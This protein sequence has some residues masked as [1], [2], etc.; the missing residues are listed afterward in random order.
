MQIIM[1][2]EI[3]RNILITKGKNENRDLAIVVAYHI[4]SHQITIIQ[5]NVHVQPIPGFQGLQGNFS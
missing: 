4:L 3:G 1:K 5:L 2:F